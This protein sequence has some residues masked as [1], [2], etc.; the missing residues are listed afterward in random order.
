MSKNKGTSTFFL[1]PYDRLNF[2]D[3]FI[4]VTSDIV[5][6]QVTKVRQFVVQRAALVCGVKGVIFMAFDCEKL[7]HKVEA[8]KNALENCRKLQC[9]DMHKNFHCVLD[10]Q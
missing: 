3:L 6:S 9:F 5:Q 2:V 10:M 1:E 8:Y 7:H 4:F